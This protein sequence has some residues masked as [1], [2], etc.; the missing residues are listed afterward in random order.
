MDNLQIVEYQGIRV[1]TTRQLADAYETD[2]QKIR[3]NFNRNKDRY[4][5]VKHYIRLTCDE[6][7][8]FRTATQIEL[9]SQRSR[10]LYLWTEKGA[11]LHAKSLNTN[12]AWE[13][14]EYLVDFYFRV[15]ERTQPVKDIEPDFKAIISQ[16][17][18]E[19]LDTM[20][21]VLRNGAKTP[22]MYVLAEK[23]KRQL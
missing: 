16:L 7:Q 23:M 2:G 9:Q 18:I 22:T 4:T 15:K 3:N 13:A 6:L 14:Y 17:P 11:L 12:K 10:I 1:M 5:E 19:A 21:K 8:S 20:E